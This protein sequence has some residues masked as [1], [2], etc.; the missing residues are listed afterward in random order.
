MPEKRFSFAIKFIYLLN[1][2]HSLISGADIAKYR[3]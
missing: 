1:G 2:V 3:A